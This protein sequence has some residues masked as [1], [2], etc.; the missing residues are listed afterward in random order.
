MFRK[1]KCAAA[2]N[3]RL[4]MSFISPARHATGNAMIDSVMAAAIA[5]RPPSLAFH[6]LAIVPAGDGYV[7][8]HLVKVHRLLP[9]RPDGVH[10]Q[11]YQG[12]RSDAGLQELSRAGW[13]GGAQNRH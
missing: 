5:P 3:Y 9:T 2:R 12:R 10:A 8:P 6:S 13:S 1:V 4:N 7:G 11:H